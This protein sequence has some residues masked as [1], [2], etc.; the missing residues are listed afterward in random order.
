MIRILSGVMELIL[1]DFFRIAKRV[2][3]FKFALILYSKKMQPSL[4]NGRRR[5]KNE[6]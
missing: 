2:D 3:K 1:Y 4:S 6:R 5:F